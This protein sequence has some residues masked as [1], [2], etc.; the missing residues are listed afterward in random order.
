MIALLASSSVPGAPYPPPPGV[1]GVSGPQASHSPLT[2]DDVVP[3][4]HDTLVHSA[5]V[6][7]LDRSIRHI[8]LPDIQ[9]LFSGQSTSHTI[10]C[11]RPALGQNRTIDL[12]R[13]FDVSNAPVAS[14]EATGSARAVTLRELVNNHGVLPLDDFDIANC[15]LILRK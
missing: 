1:S 3:F 5:Q 4:V 7:H 13:E 15:S 11:D 2:N 8:P 10:R 9:P 6:D 14:A 12:A